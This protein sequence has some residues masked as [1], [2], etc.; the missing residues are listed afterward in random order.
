M[1]QKYITNLLKKGLLEKKEDRFHTTKKGIKFV[2]TYQKLELLSEKTLT[3]KILQ[4]Q[5]I[6]KKQKL[7]FATS[8]A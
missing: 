1:C 5:R 4:R 3:S 7:G 2:E 8:F 6:R